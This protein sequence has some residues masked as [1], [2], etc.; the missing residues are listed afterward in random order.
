MYNDS[1]FD[2]QAG[3]E[4]AKYTLPRLTEAIEGLTKELSRQNDNLE[5]LN[6]KENISDEDFD[7]IMKQH[8]EQESENA[9]IPDGMKNEV[10]QNALR[11]VL[12]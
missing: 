10:F 2:T 6:K 1:F 4:F 9:R 12:K 8:Y 3:Q 11:A 7:K 5:K